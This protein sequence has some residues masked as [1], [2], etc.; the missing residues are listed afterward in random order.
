[1][2]IH[3]D[4]TTED[5]LRKV[6]ADI[7]GQQAYGVHMSDTTRRI[8]TMWREIAKAQEDPEFTFTVFPNIEHYDQLIIVSNIQ[9]SSWC[10]HH[11]LPFYGT[12]TIGYIPIEN[13]VG[14]SKLARALDHFSRRPQVQERLT[15]Q[16]GEFLNVRL[17]PL[18]VG[19]VLKAEHTCMSCRGAMKPGAV[20]TTSYMCGALMDNPTARNEFLALTSK[21]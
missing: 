7:F 21:S 10:S 13:I 1:M 15:Q 20:T 5:K 17:R 2:D 16:V 3:F 6:L 12:G 8:L 18:G 14:L 4:K 11:M 19:V 9:F